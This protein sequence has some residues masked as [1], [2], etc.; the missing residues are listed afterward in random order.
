VLD[1]APT[2]SESQPVQTARD[3]KKANKVISNPSRIRRYTKPVSRISE[4]G[5]VDKNQ[6]ITIH[7]CGDK[8]IFEKGKIGIYI[9]NKPFLIDSWLPELSRQ[10]VA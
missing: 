3:T 5:G 1:L 8:T 6:D 7:N 2:W 10:T 9:D 4:L